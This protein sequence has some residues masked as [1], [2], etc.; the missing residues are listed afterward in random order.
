MANAK[1]TTARYRAVWPTAW[2]PMGGIASKAGISG[3]ILPH[4]QPDDL[5][6]LLAWEYPKT[7]ATEG[8]FE[9]V[10][11]AS[12]AYFNSQEPDFADVRIDLPGPASFSGIV[13]RA[14][15]DIP[16]GQTL[17]YSQLAM[18]INREGAARAVATAL[19]KNPT[20]LVVPCHRVTYANG[21][22]G[23]FSAPGGTDQKRRML[24]LEAG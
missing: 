22:M 4:Y 19:S 5:Q 18:K 10:I 2:G 23:G 20:P 11:A 17:S 8:P 24:D 15:M 7:E 13:Y 16:Y 3:L 1:K 6:A 9:A 14:C 21:G 12:R